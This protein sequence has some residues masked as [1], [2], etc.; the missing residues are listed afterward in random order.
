MLTIRPH[1]IFLLFYP[2]PLPLHFSSFEINLKCSSG[3]DVALYIKPHL[4]EQDVVVNAKIG[5]DWQ[6]AKKRVFDG[7][8]Q[9]KQLIFADVEWYINFNEPELSRF[10]PL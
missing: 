8:H 9:V 3:S 10:S 4:E 2:H 6:H 1:S 5:R 7:G